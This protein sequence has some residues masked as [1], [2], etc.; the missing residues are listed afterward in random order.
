MAD[1]SVAG[2]PATAGDGQPQRADPLDQLAYMTL[3]RATRGL[4]PA[5]AQLAWHDWALHLA[6]SPGKRRKLLEEAFDGHRRF[7]NYVLRSAANPNCPNCVEPLEQDRRFEG[8]AWQKWPFNVIHQGFLLQQEWWQS[9]TSGVRGVSGQHEDMVSFSARQWLDMLSP[10]NFFWTNPEVLQ[11]TAET[12]GANLLQGARN[13]LED[14]GGLLAGAP[15]A[16][17]EGLIVGKNVGV[18]P[19]KVVFRNHLIELIQ[20]APATPRVYAAPVLIVPSWIMKYYPT[21]PK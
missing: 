10:V 9:A 7:L 17:S 2:V 16:N 20:Y 3:A 6:I 4:S 13:W 5:A 19:G 12:A 11:K 1:S 21:F 8:D 14:L 18:T 15:P